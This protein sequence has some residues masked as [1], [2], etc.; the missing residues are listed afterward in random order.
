MIV[1]LMYVAP[2]FEYVKQVKSESRMNVE[3]VISK[4]QATG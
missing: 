2:Q 4:R 3:K 1:Q